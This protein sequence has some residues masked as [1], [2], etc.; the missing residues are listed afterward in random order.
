MGYVK[1]ILENVTHCKSI[2]E[3]GYMGENCDLPCPKGYFGEMCDSK[4]SCKKGVSCDS[5]SGKCS[6]DLIDGIN[7]E[8]IKNFKELKN[9]IENHK[10]YKLVHPYMKM[11]MSKAHYA[12]S[13]KMYKEMEPNETMKVKL[14]EM[15]GHV[16]IDLMEENHYQDYLKK[17]KE[18]KQ[19]FEHIMEIVPNTKIDKKSHMS[20]KTQNSTDFDG[21]LYA[22]KKQATESHNID[23]HEEDKAFLRFAGYVLLFMLIILALVVLY[24]KMLKFEEQRDAEAASQSVANMYKKPAKIVQEPLPRKFNFK[25]LFQFRLSI[26][27]QVSSSFFI[28]PY[29][30]PSQTATGSSKKCLFRGHDSRPTSSRVST[31]KT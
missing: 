13:F 23:F 2:C 3:P 11:D 1:V 25:K 15:V 8:G 10:N 9:S 18:L 20:N 22:I 24:L 21:M 28:F 30:S 5:I 17:N 12:D 29:Y 27:H 26:I 31:R 6:D 14:H 7:I 19:K 16:D 4:C